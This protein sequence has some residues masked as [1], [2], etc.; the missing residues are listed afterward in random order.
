MDNYNKMSTVQTSQ[1]QAGSGAAAAASPKAQG[2]AAPQPPPPAI[3]HD[4]FKV[5]MDQY[6]NRSQNSEKLVSTCCVWTQAGAR[7]THRVVFCCLLGPRVKPTTAQGSVVVIVL[8][9]V[10]TH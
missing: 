2:A 1:Q 8:R 6:Q 5:L 10:C 4:Q 3:T 9:G 7:S